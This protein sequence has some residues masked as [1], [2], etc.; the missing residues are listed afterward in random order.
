MIRRETA[1]HL[2]ALGTVLIWGTTFISTK[3]LLSTV[4]PV[5][6]LIDRFLIGYVVMLLIKP[7]LLPFHS[8]K[9]EALFAAAGF[10]GLVVYY[11]LENM[12]LT[13]TLAS[14]VSVIVSIAPLFT[15]L[16]SKLLW[17]DEPW[18]LPFFLG[19]LLAIVGI[20]W[21]SFAGSG[22]SFHLMGDLLCILAAIAWAV[23]SILCKKISA[24]GYSTI[25]TTRRI[26]FYGILLMI[27]FGFAMDFHWGL[28]RFLSW[29]V[30]GNFLF[31]GVLASAICFMTWNWSVGVLGAVRTS[32]YI[33][34][35]PAVTVM[36][37]TLILQEPL[38]WSSVGGTVLVLA[39]LALSQW[40][41]GKI[42]EKGEIH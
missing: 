14:N 3:V 18:N 16:L 21:I 4:S 26:F 7:R 33:Y 20:G 37:A 36:T 10:S 11:L 35:I 19:F 39:G 5:E 17:R 28:E 41:P 15:A 32:V 38:T 24:L 1:A 42:K 23:Y 2:V 29:E 13:Y 40:K 6:I 9:E 31:L 22:V 30:A 34:M 27:P 12:A 8:V 25:L